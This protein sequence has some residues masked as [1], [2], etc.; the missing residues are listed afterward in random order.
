MKKLLALIIVLSMIVPS[1]AGVDFDNTDDVL[2]VADAIGLTSFLSISAWVK[3][4]TDNTDDYIMSGSVGGGGFLILRDNVDSVTSRTDVFT[5]LFRTDGTQYRLSSASNSA[6]SGEWIHLCVTF[7]GSTAGADELKIY[8]NGVEDA[9]SPQTNGSGEVNP[10][11]LKIGQTNI[12]NSVMDGIINEVAIWAEV[13]SNSVLTPADIMLLASSRIKHMP[14]QVQPANIFAYWPLDQVPDGASANLVE[15][16][17]YT[18]NGNTATGNDGANNTGLTAVG[19]TILSYQPYVMYPGIS[20]AVAPTPSGAAIP[21]IR[22]SGFINILGS[23][24]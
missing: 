2:N 19:E 23:P 14:L 11:A 20:V 16:L 6:L 10:V 4:D 17:D 1:F 9:N 8:V 12:S 18:G 15:F 22:S 7:S 13:D 21:Q 24:F 5:V 3:F